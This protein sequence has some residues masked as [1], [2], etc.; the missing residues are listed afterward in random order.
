MHV[1]VRVCMC[2]CECVCVMYVCVCVC[3]CVCVSCMCVCVCVCMC[4]CVC[5][6]VCVSCMSVLKA[7]SDQANQ[8]NITLT[9]KWVCSL[10]YPSQC[11]S[12][13]LKVRTINVTVTVV[14]SHGVNE[15]L[16]A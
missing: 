15:L 1:C 13:R 12:E 9:G 2:V 14:E 7:C 3:L 16:A 5:V 6:C 8:T 11:P 10:F 4:V